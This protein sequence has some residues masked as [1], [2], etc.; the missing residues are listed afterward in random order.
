M[1]FVG[2]RQLPRWL[3]K[4]MLES[5]GIAE[6]AGIV[7]N[8]GKLLDIASKTGEFAYSIFMILKDIVMKYKKVCGYEI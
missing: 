3:C 5:I 2:I 4:E 8:G 6:L 1:T 7:E